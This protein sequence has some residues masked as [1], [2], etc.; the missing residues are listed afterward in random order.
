MMERMDIRRWK[1]PVLAFLAYICL[2]PVNMTPALSADSDPPESVSA[3]GFKALDEV[4]IASDQQMNFGQ[5]ADHDGSVVL[6]LTDMITS[7][8]NFIHYGGSPYSGIHSITGDP[9]TAVDISISTSPSGGLSLSNFTSSEGGLPL[10]GVLL[11]ENGELT[12]TVG[13]TLTVNAATTTI[14]PGQ[15]V[16]YTITSIYN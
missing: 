6:G 12:L 2:G 8:P 13:A 16:S 10:V 7:D 5:L 4:A 1:Y 15:S 9:N 14:G 3:A 11:D